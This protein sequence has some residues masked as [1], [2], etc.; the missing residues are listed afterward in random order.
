MRQNAKRLMMALCMLPLS[1]VAMAHSGEH[2]AGG[3]L[4]GLAHP[5]TGID[6]LAVMLAVGVWAAV[7]LRRQAIRPVLAFLGFMVFGAVL[8]MNGL[9]LPAMETG[10]AASV[11]VMGLML[12]ALAR[13]P[14]MHSVALISVFAVFHGNAHGVEMPVSATPLLYAAGF[15]ISTGL[16]HLG[17][18]KLGGLFERLKTEWVA[19]SMGVAIG[20]A[21]AWMLLG[22]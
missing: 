7:V 9:V 8:G 1:G 16:L 22:S 14:A 21:G 2:I 13:V 3:F 15:V 20:G 19:R 18:L 5:V 12:V 11:L 17:G 6:H 10:I 4:G